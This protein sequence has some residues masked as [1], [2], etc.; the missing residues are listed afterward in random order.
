MSLI[1]ETG[2]GVRGANSYVNV[3]YV[4]SYLT[5]RN[6]HV[7]WSALST[8]VKEAA[9]VAATDYLEK[10]FSDKFKGSPAFYFDASYAEAILSFSGQPSNGDLLTIGD[11]QYK[12]VSYLSG[13]SLEVLIGG[14]TT[15]TVTALEA[16]LNGAAGQGVLYGPTS[17]INSAVVAKQAGMALTLMATAPGTGGVLTRL[18][19]TVTNMSITAFYGGLDGGPQSL[20]WPRNRAYDNGILIEGIP[21]RLK[22]AISEYAVRA[23]SAELLP[24]P[25]VDSYAGAI[26]ER[27]AEVGPIRE[28]IK[29][30]GSTGFSVFSPYPSADK[31]LR[32]LLVSSTGGR[33]YRG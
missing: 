9:I 4:T 25:D 10:R 5:T 22:Q 27:R 28:Q 3:A 31:L 1:I 16:A 33:V 8:Q 23:S 20:S 17:P 6:R 32:P 21:D 2:S 7:A 13:S 15:N 11:Y 24:D 26:S 19:G 30:S 29:Y 12:F 14:S 18:E